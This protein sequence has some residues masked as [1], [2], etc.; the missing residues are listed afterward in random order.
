MLL[1]YILRR[2]LL[3]IPLLAIISVISFVLIQLPPGDYLTMYIM[4]LKASGYDV[5]KLVEDQLRRQYGLDKTL[6]EQYFIW[7]KN[8]L[9]EGNFGSS[10][11]YDRPVSEILA[12]RVPLTAL[13]SIATTIFVWV[14]A[15][16]IGVYSAT[17][18]YS[19]FDYTWTFVSFIGVAIP[20]FLLALIFVW[21]AFTEFGISA[22]G[23][24][25]PEYENA[26]W[27]LAKF[28][29]FL[30]HIWVPVT[31]I[32]LHSTAGLMRTMRGMTLDELN[33]QYVITAR[34]KG[35]KEIKLLMKYPVRTAL[36]PI[37]ST[38]GWMLP[39]IISGEVLVSTVLNIPTIGPVLFN[40]LRTQDMYLAGSIV[41]I[42]SILTVIGTLIS[43]LLLVWFD[44]RIRYE[45]VSR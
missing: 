3:L 45:G 35:L 31:L 17:H 28:S 21:I 41:F 32:G 34:A 12:N 27:S 30:K 19:I 18:Q 24:F 39:G 29:D 23:L 40:A 36:N 22:F 5:D 33:K 14:M 8:I 2:I 13:I 4:R 9:L 26:A 1:N 44:P 42:L 6:P 7:M 38:I 16:P 20:P 43:D 37:I 11:E 15:V 25:S 10:F